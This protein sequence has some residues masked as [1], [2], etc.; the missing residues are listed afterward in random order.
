MRSPLIVTAARARHAR[1]P[2]HLHRRSQYL[3]GIRH[4]PSRQIV[5]RYGSRIQKKTNEFSNGYEVEN[6]D[7]L[8][9]TAAFLPGA[10]QLQ[11]VPA[12]FR[13]IQ[14]DSGWITAFH[15]GIRAN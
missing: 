14:R 2:A 4:P 6:A 1:T 15:S 3:A 8:S 9:R 12:R 7:R 13:A 11:S 5:E 10:I